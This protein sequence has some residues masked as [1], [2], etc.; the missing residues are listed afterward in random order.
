M[1]KSIPATTADKFLREGIRETVAVRKSFQALNIAIINAGEFFIQARNACKDGEFSILVDCHKEEIGRTTVYRFIGYVEM[2]LE[3][4]TTD[5]PKLAHNRDKLLEH[6]KHMVVQSPKPLV[7]ILRSL[8]TEDGKP[9]MRPFGEYDAVKYAKSKLLGNGGQIE[10]EFSKVVA[11]IDVLTHFGDDNYQF[12]YP[13]GKDP[14]EYLDE[15]ETKMEAV[16]DRVRKAK[17]QGK[18]IDA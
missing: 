4:A 5:A 1:S 8:E 13:E 6:L 18:V 3:W 14:G 16:L 12:I 2:G 7:A 15:I 9:L 10:F 11:A 17:Q